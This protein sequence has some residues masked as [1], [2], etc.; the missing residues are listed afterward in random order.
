MQI[1]LS[2]EEIEIMYD[3]LITNIQVMTKQLDRDRQRNAGELLEKHLDKARL[4]K[5]RIE[6]YVK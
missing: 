3:A 6:P 5:L 2:D 1:I 4:L